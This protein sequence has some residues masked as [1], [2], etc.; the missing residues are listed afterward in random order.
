MDLA[1]QVKSSEIQCFSHPSR[2]AAVDVY[3]Q[4]PSKQTKT[5]N[6]NYELNKEIYIATYNVRS[7]H[8]EAHMIH[9]ERALTD[10]KWDIIGL[11]EVRRYGEEIVE[12]SSGNIFSYIGKTKG[13]YGVGFLVHKRWSKQIIEFKNI[14]ERISIIKIVINNCKI[15]LI[16]VYAPT[17]A[18]SLNQIEEFYK[19]LDEAFDYCKSEVIFTIG[20]FNARLGTRE[21]GE[22]DIMGQFGYGTR[23]ERGRRLIQWLWQHKMTACNSLFKKHPRKKW[24]WSLPNENLLVNKFEIDFILS[25]KPKMIQDVEVINNLSFN[26][27]HRMVRAKLK[28][29][30][31]TR[32]LYKSKNHL[33]KFVPEVSKQSYN[34]NLQQRRHVLQS[35]NNDLQTC[36]N[37]M[38][39]SIKSAASTHILKYHPSEHHKLSQKTQ[40]LV[41]KRDSLK[42][43]SFRSRQENLELKYLNT[44]I[45]KSTEEDIKHFNN[46]YVLEIMNGNR[47]IKKAH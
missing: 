17:A 35:S 23:N 5:V 4:T 7:L 14:S 3:G 13:L 28:I 27:D 2:V 11:S 10:K 29:N 40:L 31:Q 39:K 6:G 9:L 33:P 24:T 42:Q 22:D 19:D 38:E 8:S 45:K 15:S 46:K 34:I 30:H 25:N 43:K 47:S 44:T 1:S 32:Q 20:D 41:N 36:Y 16:Q 12:L 26:S 21:N 37:Q 18:A